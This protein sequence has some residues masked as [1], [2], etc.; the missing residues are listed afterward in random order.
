MSEMLMHNPLKQFDDALFADENL[1]IWY[2]FYTGVFFKKWLK[3]D[4]EVLLL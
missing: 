2:S 4:I 3:V 1:N